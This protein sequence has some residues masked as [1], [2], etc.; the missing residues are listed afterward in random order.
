[1]LKQIDIFDP[2]MC[3]STGVCGTEVDQDLADFA[4]TIKWLKS[5]GVSVVRHNLG[6]EPEAFKSHP[7]VLSKLKSEGSEAL[8][9]IVA[10]NDI[11]SE[12]AYPSRQQMAAWAGLPANGASPQ[13]D[14]L[15]ELRK[16]VIQGD[17]DAMARIFTEAS[18]SGLELHKVVQMIQDGIN[19]RQETTQ[20]IAQKAN[21]LL[22][23]GGDGCT[24][25]G[26]CC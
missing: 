25:G 24:P 15:S 11:V 17:A 2:A 4:N 9:I 19:T 13:S 8:P 6:Q 22:G 7:G 21:E 1:M 18:E 10:D 5:M 23:A 12:R 14:L 20:S 26:G 16:S 3:C